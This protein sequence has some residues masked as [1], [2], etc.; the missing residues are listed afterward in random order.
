LPKL[1]HAHSLINYDKNKVIRLVTGTTVKHIYIKDLKTISINLP[2]LI[3]EQTKIASFL[4]EIDKK[5]SFVEKKLIDSKQ[6]KKSLLQQM[7]I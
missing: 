2:S 4:T 7:F 1:F 5:V 3:E 6:Y